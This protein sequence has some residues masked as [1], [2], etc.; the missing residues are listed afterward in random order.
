MKKRKIPSFITSDLKQKKYKSA[1]ISYYVENLFKNNLDEFPNERTWLL[2]DELRDI[3]ERDDNPSAQA[4]GQVSARGRIN[5]VG[6]VYVTQFYNKIPNCVKGAKLN[7][8]IALTHSNDEIIRDIANDFDLD[9][10]TRKQITRLRKYHAVAMTKNKFI[11]YKNNERRV[12]EGE[13]VS[14]QIFFP[15]S[16]H[17]KPE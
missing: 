7:Y 2:F 14:G 10:K 15:L 1:V 4:I 17:R 16:N 8:L 3:C 12:I 11:G 13:V 6:L 5:Q 9:K